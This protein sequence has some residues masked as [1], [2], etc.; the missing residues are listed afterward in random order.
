M[1]IT[2]GNLVKAEFDLYIEMDTNTDFLISWY[3]FKVH[4][5]NLERG[6]R[7][8]LNLRNYPRSRSMYQDG[9]LPRF[10]YCDADGNPTSWTTSGEVTSNLKWY[11]TDKQHSFDEEWA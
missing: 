6:S 1:E 4:T 11:P 3:Y 2:K 9:M 10:S 8:R 7:I 5:K